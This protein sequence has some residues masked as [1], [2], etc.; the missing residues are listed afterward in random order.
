MG[1]TIEHASPAL[2][3]PLLSTTAT[4]A[5]ILSAVT[6]HMT[7]LDVSPLSHLARPTT[8]NVASFPRSYSHSPLV[9]CSLDPDF[10]I[11]W[12]DHVI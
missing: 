4:C 9:Q 12:D 10:G 5:G 7:P 3:L 8:K 2:P 1:T 6:T 11:T